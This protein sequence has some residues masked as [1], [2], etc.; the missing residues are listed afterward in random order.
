[1]KK[2]SS[3]LADLRDKKRKSIAEYLRGRRKEVSLLIE[4]YISFLTQSPNE[5]MA[6]PFL[7]ELMSSIDYELIFAGNWVQARKHK[8]WS[9]HPDGQKKNKA[10]I[11]K[12]FVKSQKISP[13]IIVNAHVDIVPPCVNQKNKSNGNLISGRGTC[14]TKANLI[15][16]VEAL[17]CLR[18]LNFCSRYTITF[19]LPC[20]EEVG[21]N[22]T[23]A[24]LLNRTGIDNLAGA[25][26]LEPTELVAYVGH[27]GCLTYKLEINGKTSHMGG[28]TVVFD[29]IH[30]AAKLILM[31]RDFEDKLNEKVKATPEYSWNKRPFQITVAQIF[32]GG[33]LGSSSEHCT[34]VG[35]IGTP[36]D[37]SF[38]ETEMYLKKMGDETIDKTLELKWDFFTG[39]RNHPYFSKNLG[40]LQELVDYSRSSGKKYIWSASCDAR[41][42]HR[43]LNIPTIIFGAG[44]LAKAHSPEEEISLLEIEKGAELI[45]IWLAG[46]VD[47]AIESL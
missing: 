21:G 5:H 44:Q 43:I 14:D 17:R 24:L 6:E 38:E 7:Q 13:E 39:L 22:G 2:E 18:E 41:H 34:L 11:A 1:M 15:M 42:Y 47:N 27:R 36:L 25:I 40:L 26:C 10:W 31:L 8:D 20:Y 33:W 35:N 28:G 45:A 9:P 16:I 37:L 29:P 4:R 46:L 3:Y 23:L 32:G 12:S 19:H 30:A